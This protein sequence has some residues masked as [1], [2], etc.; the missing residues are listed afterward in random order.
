MA[1][2]V[3][4][5]GPFRLEVRERRLLRDGASVPLSGKAFDT[6]V[7]LVEGA[8]TLQ[9]QQ[10]LMD[11]LW[12]GTFVEPNNLQ[13]NISLIR[14]ALEGAPGVELQTVRG[15]GYRLVTRVA[16]LGAT[17]D[18]SATAGTGQRTYFCKAADGARLA[19]A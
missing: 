7:L 11:R 16:P 10:G 1:D 4:T 9:R 17:A 12:P 8:G 5:F 14:R 13:V 6:L 18:P 19:Y 15:Q 3:Y 2:R